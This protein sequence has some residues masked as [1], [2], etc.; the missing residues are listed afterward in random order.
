MI[1]SR[2]GVLSATTLDA[3]MGKVEVGGRE[4]ETLVYNGQLPG[5]DAADAGR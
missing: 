5:P 4:V 2:D 1:E 3:K